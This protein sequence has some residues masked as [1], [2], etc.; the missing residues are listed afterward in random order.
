MRPTPRKIQT[1]ATEGSIDVGQGLNTFFVKNLGPS[2]VL[3][4]F[5]ASIDSDAYLLEVGESLEMTFPF[6][7]MFHKTNSGTSTLH[8]IKIF[9]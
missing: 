1:T 2:D 6:I 3:I 7:R 5:D 9:Q 4:N 8:T